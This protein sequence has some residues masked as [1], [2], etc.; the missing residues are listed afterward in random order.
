[1]PETSHSTYSDYYQG[2]YGSYVS[3]SL[4]VGDPPVSLVHINQP[5]GAYPDP[6]LPFLALGLFR[7]ARSRLTGHVGAARF[8]GRVTRGSMVVAPVQTAT[9]LVVD[10][11]HTLLMIA[12]PAA[13]IKRLFAEE[14]WAIMDFGELH[15]S[16]FRDDL[17]EQLCL[18]FWNRMCRA[19]GS[20]LFVDA[21]VMT[22]ISCLF[23]HRG[24]R[25]VLPT[26]TQRSGSSDWR[27][28]RAVDHLR[29]HLHEDMNLATLA[30]V[31]G[32]SP[33]YFARQFRQV[34]GMPPHQYLIE[35][36]VERARELLTDSTCSITQIALDLGFGS[37]EH[38][39]AVFRKKMGVSPRQYRS[40]HD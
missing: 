36:R 27:V 33:Y 38:F 15:A 17:I 28:Q 16:I 24:T 12:L 37:P 29:A 14:R 2:R 11:P 6:P 18:R 31:A 4:D 34:L 8:S 5:A 9:D 21:A 23:E 30:M 19:Q 32:L 20:C 13:R 39:S 3:Q 25:H 1:M 26:A 22:I 7:Q 10:G 40:V 35:C